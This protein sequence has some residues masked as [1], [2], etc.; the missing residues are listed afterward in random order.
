MQSIL[1]FEKSDNYFESD[2]YDNFI[3]EENDNDIFAVYNKDNIPKD[4]S[5]KSGGKASSRSEPFDN[6]GI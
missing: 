6:Y 3:D 5:T 1:A 2:V 4:S